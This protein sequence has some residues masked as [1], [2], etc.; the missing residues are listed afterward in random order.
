GNPREDIK[1][2]DMN[3]GRILR[4]ARV[5]RYGQEEAAKLYRSTP[6][7]RTAVILSSETLQQVARESCQD[8]INDYV[9]YQRLS[10]LGI[11]RN[12]EF[13]QILQSLSEM[14]HRH[15]EFW[16]KYIPDARI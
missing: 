1:L 16:K 4:S 11:E 14:E 2:H 7:V 6:G 3:L 8:E 5:H 10:R 13:R 15:Y 12:Q 9:V